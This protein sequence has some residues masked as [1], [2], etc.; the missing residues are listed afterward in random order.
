MESSD[1]F[2]CSNI[3]VVKLN[4]CSTA[5]RYQK[6]PLNSILDAFAE[7]AH[8]EI[9]ITSADAIC[10]M[11]KL[12]L[13]E[14]DCMRFK[15]KN[16]EHMIAHKL[17]RKYQFDDVECKLP[18][19]RLDEHTANLYGCGGKNGDK[20]QCMNCVF[21]TNFQD[22]LFPHML[23]HQC[24]DSI[25]GNKAIDGATTND[26]P[27]ENCRLILPT[28]ELF[29][30]HMSMFHASMDI[31]IENGQMDPGDQDDDGGGCHSNDKG[32]QCKVSLFYIFLKII[33]LMMFH[34]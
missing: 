19:I 32:F 27:C 17:H 13:D 11:C 25:E 4:I 3:A 18:A 5:T 33:I 9:A 16:I 20:Y 6:I 7:D 22:C 10:L 24:A 1:C 14:L 21:S 23:Y 12:L 28:E 8:I 26:F 29:S 15:L 34:L 30:R 2:L 31:K